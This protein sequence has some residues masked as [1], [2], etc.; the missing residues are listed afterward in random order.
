[1]E[2]GYKMGLEE[3][4]RRRGSERAKRKKRDERKTDIKV[5]GG[6]STYYAMSRNETKNG[7]PSSPAFL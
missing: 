5:E 6:F 3:T 2:R 4:D 1:M 7:T